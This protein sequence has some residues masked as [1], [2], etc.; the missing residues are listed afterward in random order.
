M[1]D[2]AGFAEQGAGI[3]ETVRGEQVGPDLLE[4]VEPEAVVPG[5]PEAPLK[6][7]VLHEVEAERH[8]GAAP[9]QLPLVHHGRLVDRADVAPQL[10]NRAVQVLHVA[11]QQLQ[12][13]VAIDVEHVD[14]QG[15]MV[16]EVGELRVGDQH[17]MPDARP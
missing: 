5:R 2:L 7:R 12:H 1:L 8:G 14:A 13:A 10:E 16:G 11:A 4:V 3:V 15:A 9:R 6:R 17:V